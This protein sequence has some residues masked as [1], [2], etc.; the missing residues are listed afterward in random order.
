MNEE[1]MKAK[2]AAL[3]KE[4]ADYKA[5]SDT[6][7]QQIKDKDVEIATMRDKARE[8]G[9]NFKKLRDYTDAEKEL[10]T[11]KEKEIIERQEAQDEAFKKFTHFNTL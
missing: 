1:E 3:E 5:G 2:I 6:L 9:L 10:L 7:T 11:E 4:N 8:Q